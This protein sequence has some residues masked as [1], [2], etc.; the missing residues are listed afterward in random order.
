MWLWLFVCRIVDRAASSLSG[1][2]VACDESITVSR[3][4]SVSVYYLT[5]LELN[6]HAN[7]EPVAALSARAFGRIVTAAHM[8]CSCVFYVSAVSLK[9]CVDWCLYADRST[10]ADP[11]PLVPAQRL[12]VARL[13]CIDADGFFGPPGHPGLRSVDR[14]PQE[15]V[16]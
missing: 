7:P 15:V 5:Y 12:C 10:F 1:R 11:A 3:N 9:P 8:P 13:L 2:K 4:P 6:V 14:D 16:E